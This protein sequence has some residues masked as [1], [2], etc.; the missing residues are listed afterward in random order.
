MK[1]T[2]GRI[3]IY[4]DRNQ[5]E[6]PAIIVRVREGAEGLDVWLSQFRDDNLHPVQWFKN[7]IEHSTDEDAKGKY[8]PHTWHWPVIAKEEPKKKNK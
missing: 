8:L 3:V 7:P 4:V 2:I 1:P 6:W 5:I